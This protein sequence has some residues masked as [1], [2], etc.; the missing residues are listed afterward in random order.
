MNYKEIIKEIKK[1]KILVGIKVIYD[2]NDYTIY[3]KMQFIIY[4]KKTIQKD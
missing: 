3:K 2:D 4:I 1:N